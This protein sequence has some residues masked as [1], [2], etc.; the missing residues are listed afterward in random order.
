MLVLK[1]RRDLARRQTNSL[2]LVADYLKDAE[3]RGLAKMTLVRYRQVFRDFFA[4]VGSIPL[5]ELKPRDVRDFLAWM[6]DRGASDETLRAT[7]CA[8]RSI[9]RFAEVIDAVSVS[10]ARAVQTRR[11]KRR[12]PQP[13][14]EKEIDQL[15][16]ATQTPRDKALIEFLYSTGCRVAEV[17]GAR[18][19]NVSWS[20]RTLRVVGKGNKERLVP[21]NGRA[22]G[23]L[24]AHLGNRT[25]GFLF[26]GGRPDQRGGVTKE[27][28][29]FWLGT[30]RE[31]Y[32]IG[33]DGILRSSLA[34][35]RLGKVAEMS[36]EEAR[37]KLADLI[38]DKLKP[39]PRRGQPLTIRAIRKIV[40]QTALKA[41]LG[42]VHP[43]QLRHSFATHLLDHGADL[44]A[45]KELLGH[46]SVSTTQIYTHVSQAKIRE[47]IELHP[48][49]RQP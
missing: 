45:I 3:Q 43:H 23:L 17:S 5:D 48:H 25:A 41:G 29:K 24:K 19:E 30:W 20:D 18:I 37:R 7:L 49:W 46:V 13:L 11:V 4:V 32:A 38:A 28:G 26:E 1:P 35:K 16:V 9:F 39:R 42:H 27:F 47:S 22:I 8:L 31:D 10:P 40:A 44:M 15:I 14:S 36:R 33:S 2:A 6:Q 12:L 21:L 34:K